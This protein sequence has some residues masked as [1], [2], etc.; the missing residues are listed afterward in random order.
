MSERFDIG[1]LSKYA[2][3][4]STTSFGLMLIFG[5]SLADHVPE[6]AATSIGLAL[7]LQGGAPIGNKVAGYFN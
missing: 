4:A 1:A 5:V 2:N 7:F 3:S 6:V